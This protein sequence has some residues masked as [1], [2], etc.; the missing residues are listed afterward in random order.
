MCIF[1]EEGLSWTQIK[2]ELENMKSNLMELQNVTLY[3]QPLFN[4]QSNHIP[5]AKYSPTKVS[6]FLNKNRQK[7]YSI[8]NI[9]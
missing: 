6:T 9:K 2:Q 5:D 4:P 3:E 8:Q 1:I 7:A